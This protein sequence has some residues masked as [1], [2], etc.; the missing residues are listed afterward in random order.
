VVSKA[1]SVDQ[2][3]CKVRGSFPEVGISVKVVHKVT[4]FNF[5]K[6]ILHAVVMEY[7]YI[8][9]VLRPANSRLLIWRDV[10]DVR[11]SLH[12]GW[13]S[14]TEDHSKWLQKESYRNAYGR[15]SGCNIRY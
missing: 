15:I 14:P 4:I 13:P 11:R 5:R 3:E 6:S 1:W 7:I 10:F 12:K 2:N 8:I 9:C